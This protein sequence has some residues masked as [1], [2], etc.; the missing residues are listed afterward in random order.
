MKRIVIIGGGISGLT[1]AYRL[2]QRLPGAE[3]TV[4][5]R[6]ARIGGKIGTLESAGFRVE[7]GPNGVLDNKP[8]VLDLCRE[9]GLG[10]RLVAASEAARVNRFLFLRG[11]LRRLP[12]GLGSFLASPILSLRSK[13]AIMLER[14]RPRRH[15][16][17]DESIDSFVRR[18]RCR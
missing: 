16:T 2:E 14:F 18:R 1:V 3:V 15:D 8:H 13:L 9:L 12:S 7:M 10:D 17:G 5:E 6:E 11:R 4:L